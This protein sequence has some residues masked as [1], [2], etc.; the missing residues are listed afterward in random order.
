[1]KRTQMFGIT[2][3]VAALTAMVGCSSGGGSN[4]TL[5]LLPASSTHNS[6]GRPGIGTITEYPIPH[7]DKNVPQTFPVGITT[8][9][10]GA[11]WFAE[12]GAGKLGRIDPSTDTITEPVRLRGQ[13]R[14]PW[15]VEVGSDGSLWATGGSL[16]T[17]RQESHGTPDP[18]ASIWQVTLGPTITATPFALPMY[19]DPRNILLG[20][21]GNQYFGEHTGNVGQITTAG[22]ITQ[23]PVPHANPVNAGLA[24]A[25]DGAI[26]FAETFHNKLGRI[27]MDGEVATCFFPGPAG[28]ADGPDGNLWVSEF[29]AGKVAAV[30]PSIP[31]HQKACTISGE[32]ALSSAQS[33]PKGVA[34]GSDGN[35]YFAEFGTGKIAQVT[36]DGAVNEI[37][38]PTPNSGPW[39]LTS[40]PDGNIWFTES[41][42]GKI[43]KLTVLTGH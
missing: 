30:T 16:R 1:M 8:G 33:S 27:A 32:F 37:D 24:V 29:L 36:T 26:W 31:Q 9:P 13:A 4:S 2:A 18:Y 23:I 41:L 28:I 34:V 20:P 21:D 3:C 7:P 35:L 10:D 5:G 11:L 42:V 22:Q 40:G 6:S 17:Y 14:F 38:I 12:R 15:S 19:S 39:N 25:P 43:G